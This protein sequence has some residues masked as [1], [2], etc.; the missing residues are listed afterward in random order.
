[1]ETIVKQIAYLRNEIVVRDGQL[2]L[3]LIVFTTLITASFIGAVASGKQ[4]L[5]RLMIVLLLS[6]VFYVGR[7]EY[8]E[9]RNVPWITTAEKV[10]Q[11]GALE[12]PKDFVNWEEYLTSLKSRWFYLGLTD[13]FCGLAF[14]WM[15]SESI[16]A[17]LKLKPWLTSEQFLFYSAVVL[18]FAICWV[19]FGRWAADK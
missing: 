17:M 19:F 7:Q 2:M 15:F 16:R 11:A 18:A 13:F 6:G 14:F 9:K 8:L 10:V 3:G 12:I 5:Y 4:L 1:M